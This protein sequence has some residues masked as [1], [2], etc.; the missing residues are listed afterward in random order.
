MK[1]D[2]DIR[3]VR[4]LAVYALE[5]AAA[6]G[7]TILPINHLL[8]RMQ[9][10]PLQPECAVTED[11]ITVIEDDIS[12]VIATKKMKDGSKYY[13]LQ[14]YEDFDHEIERKI[15]KKLKLGRID[16]QA[17]WRKILD[18]YLFGMGVPAATEDWDEQARSEKA[19][20]LQELAESRISILV[21]DAGTG[22]TTVLAALCSHQDIIDG[23]VLLLA[24]TGK[25][26]VRL[27]EA[28]G[29]EASKFDAY[30]VAQFL[31]GVDR[32]DFK[33]MRYKLSE[34][35]V[36]KKYETVIVDE[37]SMLTEEMFGSLMQAVGASKR[38]I[39]VGDPNQLPPIGAGRPF[40]D[41]ISILKHDFGK[42]RP[43]VK[44][45]YCELVENCRQASTGA[46][47][48]VEFAKMFTDSEIDLERNIV[49]EIA[50]GNGENIRLLR[51]SSK[52]ELEEKLFQ[53]MAEEYGIKD[54]ESFD[55]S[56]GGHRGNYGEAW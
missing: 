24:P 39:F 36:T 4:A 5:Q 46:R 50:K 45:G 3:R 13:K 8:D 31:T 54:Q 34:I 2:N 48:D 26:T 14:R 43:R 22:K 28:M 51:W 23:G 12:D 41:L 38:I 19:V 35:S 18:D 20:A 25:A 53:V 10:I 15:K 47:L 11:H 44:N 1:S 37:S 27:L 42:K 56:F 6:D 9:A 30:N 55:K 17:D 21:G 49:T 16:I 40:V 29:G 33:D 7:S 32:F 52:E